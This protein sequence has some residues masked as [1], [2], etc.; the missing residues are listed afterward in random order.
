MNV[1]SIL[2]SP[3]KHGNTA[4]ILNEYLEGVKNLTSD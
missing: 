4:V 2:A 1:L 3:R